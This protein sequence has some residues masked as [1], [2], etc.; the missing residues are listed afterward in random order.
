MATGLTIFPVGGL[1]KRNMAWV[2]CVLTTSLE[3][4]IRAQSCRNN[5]AKCATR[6]RPST[7]PQKEG[8]MASVLHE[9][10]SRFCRQQGTK[11]DFGIRFQRLH[12]LWA[13]HTSKKTIASYMQSNAVSPSCRDGH[14]SFCID[15][16]ILISQAFMDCSHAPV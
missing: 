12:N 7:V 5:G 13:K 6:S 10:D 4:P 11:L 16:D 2:V 3:S 8:T 14:T 9:L 1:S 15:P